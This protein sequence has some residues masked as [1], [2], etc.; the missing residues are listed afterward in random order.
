MSLAETFS[1]TANAENASL[2]LDVRKARKEIGRVSTKMK[3]LNTHVR[4]FHNAV[5]R[6]SLNA[7]D[8][9]RFPKTAD[10]ILK[11]IKE[12]AAEFQA[13]G[14]T[15]PRIHSLVIESFASVVGVA[16]DASTLE[17][18]MPSAAELHALEKLDKLVR[19]MEKYDETNPLYLEDA[20]AQKL[21]DLD[22]DREVSLGSLIESIKISGDRPGFFQRLL[23]RRHPRAVKQGIKHVKEDVAAARTAM[24]EKNLDDMTENLEK[25]AK[26]LTKEEQGF[27]H[28][29]IDIVTFGIQFINNVFLFRGILN[30]LAEK[31]KEHK[32]E[33]RDLSKDYTQLKEL[34]N[35]FAN[36]FLHKVDEVENILAR[37]EEKLFEKLHALEDKLRGETAKSQR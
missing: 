9:K 13:L 25:A 30:V 22:G 11:D 31:M 8:Q 5:K 29:Q 14:F 7:K 36:F 35:A 2:W 1:R 15:L 20:L 12:T 3:K 18:P 26:D 27:I 19:K 21:A 33:I 6:T 32:V 23:G 34:Q 4:A 16:I 24:K 10:T 28:L 17:V 37:K